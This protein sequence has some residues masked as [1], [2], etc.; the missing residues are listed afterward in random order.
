MPSLSIAAYFPFARVKIVDHM[1][2][3]SATMTTI[4]VAPDLRFK[5]LCHGCGE[6][7]RRVHSTGHVRFIRDLDIGPATNCLVAQYRKVYCDKCQGVRVEEQSFCDAGKRMTR[8]FMRMLFEL[9]KVLTVADV[10]RRF[11]VDPKT[12][13]AL[14]LAGLEE[15]HGQTDYANLR[16]LAIDEIAVKKGHVYMT[17]VLDYLSGR[18]VA[19]LEGRKT[20]TL[21]EFFNGMSAE[22]K[23]GIEAVAMDM[24][25][26]FINRVRQHCPKAAIVFDL[27]HVVK[28]F[29]QVIDEVRR[30][31]Y[32]QAQEAQKKILK[33]SRYILLKNT[34]NLSFKQTS[35]LKELLELNATLNAVYVLKDQLK[36]IYATT[37]RWAAQTALGEWCRMAGEVDHPYM[38]RFVHRLRFF[39]YGILNHCE[40]PIGTSKLEGVNNKIKVIKRKAYGFQDERYF[41]LKIMQAF[42]GNYLG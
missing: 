27:F 30:D 15:Q 29:S 5:P 2:N 28:A 11:G 21:D 3:A 1:P 6:E 25:E 10:S 20:E 39:E 16:I 37:S 19:V 31:E 12:V 9:C 4:G 42:P 24:W 38:R 17:V 14:D 36:A 35:R 7:A 40:N 34:E 13:K 26:P 8:R 22:Q 18:V 33:G 32:A 23:A 41:A